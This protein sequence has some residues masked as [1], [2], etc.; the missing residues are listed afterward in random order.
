MRVHMRLPGSWRFGIVTAC[1]TARPGRTV[2]LITPLLTRGP[3]SASAEAEAEEEATKPWAWSAPSARPGVRWI[4]A[5]KRAAPLV[6]CPP[7][8]AHPYHIPRRTAAKLVCLGAA[9]LVKASERD[10]P[11]TAKPIRFRL[12]PHCRLPFITLAGPGLLFGVRAPFKMF[13][14]LHDAY[15]T[16]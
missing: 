14:E 13:G 15:A 10:V 6:S 8:C 1:S 4:D 3:A 5:Y 9:I 2:L 7:S 11:G 12:V 16:G